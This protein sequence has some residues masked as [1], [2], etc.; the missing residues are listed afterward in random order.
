MQVV[1]WFEALVNVH[2]KKSKSLPDFVAEVL[3]G[4]NMTHINIHNM[5]Y[6][7]NNVQIC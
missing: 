7:N 6:T 2:E 3:V 4:F 1:C 5:P